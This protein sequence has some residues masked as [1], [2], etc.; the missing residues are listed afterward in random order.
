MRQV[1]IQAL[2]IVA[3]A[4]AALAIFTGLPIALFGSQADM[5]QQARRTCLWAGLALTAIGIA[6]LIL[7]TR[8]GKP[9]T[10]LQSHN[11]D[12]LPKW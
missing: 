1:H 3:L 11:C 12:N 4:A 6:I 5:S 2:R 8:R 9:S 10:K 7:R